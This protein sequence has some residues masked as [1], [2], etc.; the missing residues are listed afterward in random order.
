MIRFFFLLAIRFYQFFISPLIGPVCRFSPSCSEYT[1]EAI[2]VY[3]PFKGVLF[4][5]KRLLKC[6]PFHPGGYDPL[7]KTDLLAENRKRTE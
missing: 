4:G 5:M 1:Y 7:I 2:E 3:G 6:H